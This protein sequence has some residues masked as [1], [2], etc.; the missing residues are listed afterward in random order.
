MVPTIEGEFARKR[1]MMS[2]A[3]P[4]VLRGGLL[5]PRGYP[6][7]YALMIVSHRLLRYASPFLHVVALA[8]AA[9][10]A[11][12]SRACARRAGRAAR[13]AGRRRCGRRASVP[14]R[15]WSRATTC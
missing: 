10:A 14:G 9:A 7:L 3:W 2:H 13:R 11:P 6:P 5:S 12:R 15:C 1:R 4:I 8:A